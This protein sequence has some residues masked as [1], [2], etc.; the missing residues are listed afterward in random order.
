MPRDWKDISDD[1]VLNFEGPQTAII[2]RYERIMDQ[3]T[4]NALMEV[5]AGLFDVKKSMHVVTDKLE[6]RLIEAEKI[7][8]EAAISQNKLQRVTIALTV[9]IAL[10]TVVYT[11]ITWQ[12]VQAQ[13]EANQIQRET[14]AAEKQSS[15]QMPS[16]T[17]Y[18]DSPQKQGN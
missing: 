11:W 18:M 15:A 14:L 10:S 4:I 7:Q 8:K 3:K 16:N 12:S 17:A 5:R 2:A 1:E 13:H 9:V 6:K